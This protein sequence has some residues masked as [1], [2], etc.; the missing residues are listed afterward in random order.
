MSNHNLNKIADKIDDM[1]KMVKDKFDKAEL[2]SF[3]AYTDKV[4]TIAPLVAFEQWQKLPD[5]A[6][7]EA[8]KRARLLLKIKALKD[9]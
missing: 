8:R 3:I 4:D 6:I 2:E 5:D 1:V 7:D 9:F